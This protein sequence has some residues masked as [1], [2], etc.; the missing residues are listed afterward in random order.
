MILSDEKKK[1]LLSQLC[2]E[3]SNGFAD[4]TDLQSTKDFLDSQASLMTDMGDMYLALNNH[5]EA[6]WK[7][8]QE[9]VN[10]EENSKEMG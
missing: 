10:F 7:A 8:A 9:A 6:M 5:Y 4:F 1:L 3:F 2:S